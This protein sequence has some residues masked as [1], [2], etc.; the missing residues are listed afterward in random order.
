MLCDHTGS[1]DRGVESTGGERT[2]L[3]LK[4]G[5]LALGY[6]NAILGREEGEGGKEVEIRLCGWEY[7]YL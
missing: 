4:G 3:P 7:M 6:W 5:D 1:S 2:V